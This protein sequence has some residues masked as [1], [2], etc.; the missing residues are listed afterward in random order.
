MS[1]S[2]EKKARQQLGADYVSPKQQKELEEQ[3]AS[4]RTTIVFTFCALLFVAFVAFTLVNNSGVLK[5][6]AKAATVNGQTYT[7]AD[8]AYYYYNARSSILNNNSDLSNTSLR[9]QTYPASDDYDTWYDYAV[10][11][12]LKSLAS[13]D[14]TAK[15]AKAAGFTSAEADKT[16]SDTLEAIKTNAASSG[17]SLNDYIKAIFGGLV[18]QKAFTKYLGNAALAEEYASAKASPSGYSASE[19]QAELDAN[20]SIYTTVSYEAVVFSNSTFATD[21]VEATET[22]PA[23]E[24]DDGSAAALTAAQTVLALYQAGTDLESLAGQFSG[25]YMNTS[26]TYGSGSDILEWLFDANRKSGDAEVLDYSYFGYSLGS[27]VV[28]FHDSQLADYHTVNVRHILVDDEA[29]ANDVLAQFE[30]GEKTEDAFAALAA[31]YSTDTGSSENGGLYE[32]VTKG[33]MVE[34]FE[35]W[36]FDASRQSGDTGIVQTDYGYHV[37]YFVSRSEY[38]YWQELAA[39]NLAS[40]W[41]E[42]LVADANYEQLGGMK[43]ID[44]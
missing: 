2:R 14:A 38:A 42:T 9:G 26:T 11:Q 28:V 4:R 23:V 18:N 24:A 15:A 10:D 1:A 5:R 6:G 17:Y 27:V 22:E 41:Q 37:M 33:Q 8:V 40:A 32:N 12:S 43:Y 7:A 19:L 25:S 44:P 35:T 29:T 21:A 36:C 31:E 20:P 34:P 13:I 39:S 30:A 3:N 16:V